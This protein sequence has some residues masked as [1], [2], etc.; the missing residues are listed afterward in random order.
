MEIRH[1]IEVDR[2]PAAVFDFLTDS[3]NFPVVDAA[4]VEYSPHERLRLGLRG[5]F[6]HRRGGMT[7]RTT[8]EVA[9]FEPPARVRVT[10][11]G[12]GYEMDE[13]AT[14]APTTIG[15]RATFVETVRPTNLA[16][17][18]LVA[19]SGGIMRRDLDARAR[20]LKTALESSATDEGVSG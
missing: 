12:M 10:V 4:L 1:E 2:T 17:R 14:L 16:G 9:E 5:T 11:R 7:A 15:T 20:L 19:L 6:A 8:W 13:I 18:L 3:A